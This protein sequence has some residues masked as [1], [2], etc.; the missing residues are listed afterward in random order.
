MLRVVSCRRG[1]LRAVSW[2]D[3]RADGM[4]TSVS[5]IPVQEA[6]RLLGG[7]AAQLSLSVVLMLIMAAAFLQRLLLV[8]LAI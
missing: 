7:Q 5:I 2:A 6:G 3:D 1:P 4:L 8:G